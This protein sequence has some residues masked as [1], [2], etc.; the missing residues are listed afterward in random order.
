MRKIT[1]ELSPESCKKALE[2]IKDYKKLLKPKLDEIC[3]RLAEIGRDT[4][5]AIFDK[6]GEGNGGVSV[7]AVPCENGWK[8]VATG[9]DVY[10][11]EFGTGDEVTDHYNASVPLYSGSWSEEHAQRYAIYGYWYYRGV[12]YQGTPPYMP[13]FNA[14]K[15]IRTNVKRVAREVLG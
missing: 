10:F 9:S 14:E 1:L 2:E 4:A 12:R 11:I 3:K 8:V 6:A 7:Q 13:M 5:Q 15:A